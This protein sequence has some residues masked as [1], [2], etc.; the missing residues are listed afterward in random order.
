MEPGFVKDVAREAKHTDVNRLKNRTN[1]KEGHYLN[2][3][4]SCL[5]YCHV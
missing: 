5:S 3:L 2:G 4:P 1:K